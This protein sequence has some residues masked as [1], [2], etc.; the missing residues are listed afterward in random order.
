MSEPTTPDPQPA[1]PADE[2]EI[3]APTENVEESPADV[4]TLGAAP[5]RRVTPPTEQPDDKKV[6]G[7]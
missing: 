4:A 7:V 2:S 5:A 1:A 3:A 6:P